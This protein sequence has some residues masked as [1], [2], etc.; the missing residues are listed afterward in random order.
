MRIE[1]CPL[2]SDNTLSVIR[3][4]DSLEINGEVFDFSP[5]ADGDTLP[6]TEINSQWFAGQVDRVDGKLA[7]TI[8]LPLPINFS[9]EQ[10]YPEPLLDVPDG[11]VNLPQPLSDPALAVEAAE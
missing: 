3:S 2:R 11:A 4:G 10:A 9:P 5:L 1:L 7:L 8:F 6:A